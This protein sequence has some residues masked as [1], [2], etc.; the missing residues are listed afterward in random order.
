M[1]FMLVFIF[2]SS[3][4]FCQALTINDSGY[5]EKPG[6]NVFV[7]SGQYNGMF[8]DY[9]YQLVKPIT[10]LDKSLFQWREEFFNCCKRFDIKPAEACVQ[11]ALKVPGVVGV[12]S[13]TTKMK[14]VAENVNIAYM[15]IPNE[16]W[17]LMKEKGLIKE[18]CSF[19]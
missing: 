14:Q 4:S 15:N 10:S 7:F 19:L 5:F 6:V 1:S 16:F 8:Y 13:G 11:F 3:S 17:S 18:Y 12:A 2:Y 9:D